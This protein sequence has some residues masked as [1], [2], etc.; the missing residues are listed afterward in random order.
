MNNIPNYE[1]RYS[2]TKCGRIFSHV[3]NKYLQP[4]TSGGYAK[5]VLRKDGKSKTHRVHRL[6]VAA[7]FGPSDLHVNHKDGNKLNNSL[8]NLEYC[9]RSYNQSHAFRTGLIKPLRGEARS[10]SKLTAH[11]VKVIKELWLPIYTPYFISQLYGVAPTTIEQIK[12]GRNWSH[13]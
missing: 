8:N 11:Q 6:I 7:F 12:S 5:L 4:D 13:V 9:S 3:S 1:G 2:A 10:N